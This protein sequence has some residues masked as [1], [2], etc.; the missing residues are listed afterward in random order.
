MRVVATAGHVD[1]GKSTLVQTLT[2]TDPDRFAEEKERGLTIDLGF[3]FTALPS[4]EDV[5]FVDVPGH[6]RF[7]KNMLAGVGA[8]EVVLL[9]VAA[10][11]GWMPQSEEH[12]QIIELLGVRHGVVALTKADTVDA[13]TLELARLELDEHLA[14]SA[15]EAAPVVVCD[16][17]SG[18]AVDEVRTTL[19]AVLADA[20]APLDAGRPRLW[21]D[22][23]FAARGSGT[24]VT[25]TL[26]GG[27]LSVD[28][29]VE[30]G[31]PGRRAR[32]RGIETAHRR[33]EH[34][35]PGTRVALNLAGIGRDDIAR[36][37]A[38]VVPGAWRY[39][40]VVDVALRHLPGD[41]VPRRAAVHCHVGSGERKGRLR[42]L[43]EGGR[44]GRLRLSGSVPIAPGDRLVLRDP[45]RERTIA[46]AE[47]L[48]VAPTG[49][50]ADAPSRLALAP[51]LRLLA[52]HPWLRQADLP[53]LA[54]AGPAAVEA[55]VGGLVSGG[56]AAIVGDWLVSAA[57][58]ADL[59]ATA[60]ERLDAHHRDR[61][62]DAGVELQALAGALRIDVPR[63][64]AALADADGIVV[65]RGV[66]RLASHR[67]RVSG[68]PEAERLVAALAAA[69]FAPPEPAALGADQALV[70]ALVREGVLVDLEGVVFSASAIDDARARIQAALRDQPA[71][72]VA[73]VRDLLGTTRKFVIP[74]LGRLDAEGVTRRRGDERIAGAATLRSSIAEKLP[75]T[76]EGAGSPGPRTATIARE[77]RAKRA[78]PEKSDR[79]SDE[80]A[81]F[82]LGE[83]TP[84]AVLLPDAE[85]V[86]EALA[87]D[88]A[89]GADRLGAALAGVALVPA[90]G[91][92]GRKEHRGF[93]AP[94]RGPQLPRSLLDQLDGHCSPLSV[95][96]RSQRA[97]RIPG[98][99]ARQG[100]EIARH[101][102]Y[103]RFRPRPSR[104]SR[105]PPSS[106]ST[107]STRPSTA[108]TRTGSPAV[109]GVARFVRARQRDP[110]ITTTPSGATS[111]SASPI[112][113]TNPSRP[114]V[115][116]EKRL[117]MTVGIAPSMNR[118]VPTMTSASTHHGGSRRDDPSYKL[119]EP[120]TSAAVPITVHA[121]VRPAWTS[122]AYPRIAT[123]SRPSAHHVTGRC[124]SPIHAPTTQTA[125]VSPAS[126]IAAV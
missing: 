50:A 97:E 36:G 44:F 27:S 7:V 51:G 116:A 126:P 52:A 66:V 29:E 35:A 3:A 25:G 64:R 41:A 121:P 74:I 112:S 78:R 75:S 83:A 106:G 38:V 101:A 69:P 5:G 22:R 57:V 80:D 33:V 63:L 48:D 102:C 15:L 23:V 31:G 26:G 20:P 70:R 32:I 11:E 42:V 91:V 88:R 18:R 103:R 68:T 62:L 81:A 124:E 49:K 90:L 109:R 92:G 13:E 34:A 16:A 110:R 24:V 30:V 104:W 125:P 37:D 4:G 65:H 60:I 39:P 113:P 59:R 84:D 8:V 71:L 119:S 10:N 98:P 17:V 122:M 118:A 73:D 67:S 28:D 21:I 46:G 2:G 82:G 9:V 107:S 89:H 19:D 96:A 79:V 47:I 85:R 94:A 45:G 108:T 55:L 1:H 53:P 43:D 12:L 117:R 120:A 58:L 100:V 40:D 93:R 95:L 114:T 123:I 105:A 56:E 72:T 115:G 86:L 87:P 14:G 99:P 61:P 6:V 54:G 111:T 76:D 77:R